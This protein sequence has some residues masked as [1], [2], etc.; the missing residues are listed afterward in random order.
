MFRI[1]NGNGSDGR[2]FSL[3]GGVGGSGMCV[4]SRVP[5]EEL[6]TFLPRG[7]YFLTALT[8]H[9]LRKI[10]SQ[11]YVIVLLVHMCGCMFDSLLHNIDYMGQK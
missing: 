5:A 7:I 1:D 3:G 11:I 6:C 8:V 2:R 9:L 4:L 10:L